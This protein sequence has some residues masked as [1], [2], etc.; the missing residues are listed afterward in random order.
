MGI[1]E[2]WDMSPHLE[3]TDEDNEAWASF[4]EEIRTVYAGDPNLKIDKTYISFTVDEHPRLE[5]DGYRFRRFS[6]KISGSCGGARE[7]LTGVKHIARRHFGE[8]VF[9]WSELGSGD[10]FGPYGWDEVYRDYSVGNM[11]Q[12]LQSLY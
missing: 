10:N 2:G 3:D 8:R 4:L 12:I 7:Y 5:L 11:L 9:P 6:S 1:D